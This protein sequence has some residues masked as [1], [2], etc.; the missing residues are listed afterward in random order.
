MLFNNTYLCI[1]G[2]IFGLI[3]KFFKVSIFI[4]LTGQKRDMTELKLV[5]PVNMTSHSSNNI[6]SPGLFAFLVR[7]SAIMLCWTWI[8]LWGFL[9]ISILIY[10]IT[11]QF[12]VR[13]KIPCILRKPKGLTILHLSEFQCIHMHTFCVNPISVI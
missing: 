8:S 3:E 10:S 2:N 7:L 5:W 9:W 1:W 12:F 11:S 4:I 13:S 6:F